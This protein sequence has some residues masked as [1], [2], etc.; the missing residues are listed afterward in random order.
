VHEAAF[1][2]ESHGLGAVTGAELGKQAAHM[3][4]NG[5]LGDGQLPRDFLV[6]PT[7][8]EQLKDGL[9]APRE[10][11]RGLVRLVLGCGST[12]RHERSGFPSG[13][14]YRTGSADGWQPVSGFGSPFAS[15]V[16]SV[17]TQR[18]RAARACTLDQS[19]GP[20]CRNSER[21]SFS[22]RAA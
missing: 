16:G 10:P 19:R 4:F 2:G 12:V 5:A 8:C 6:P 13:G 15:G 14:A 9:L 21:N 3:E 18:Q 22:A 11:G 17:S 7:V 1:K 20:V